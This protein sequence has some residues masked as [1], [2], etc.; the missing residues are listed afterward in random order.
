MPLVTAY[1]DWIAQQTA[2]IDDPANDLAEYRAVA[3]QAMQECRR[4]LGR[5]RD[6]IA[7]L[8]Q[9]GTCR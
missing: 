1:E 4:T 9:N 3:L 7:L 5:I 2:R 6:G 8:A